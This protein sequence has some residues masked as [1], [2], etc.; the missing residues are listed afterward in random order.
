MPVVEI[1]GLV[2]LAVVAIGNYIETWKNTSTKYRTRK[3]YNEMITS[4]A[5]LRALGGSFKSTN[6]YRRCLTKEES[7]EY[8]RLLEEGEKCHL[9]SVQLRSADVPLPRLEE[10]AAEFKALIGTIEYFMEPYREAVV[11]YS[12]MELVLIFQNELPFFETA[13]EK[14]KP[15]GTL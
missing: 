11:G 1:S 3:A 6:K 13:F 4:C 14:E 7:E 15:W 5:Q 2:L 9:K 10:Q 12:S 8:E